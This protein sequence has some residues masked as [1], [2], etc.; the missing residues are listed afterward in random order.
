MV[1]RG[2]M[3]EAHGVVPAGG[4]ATMMGWVGRRGRG[5]LGG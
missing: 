4:D 1:G 2:L 5:L 3:G